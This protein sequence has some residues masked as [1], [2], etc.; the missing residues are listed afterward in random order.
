M[1]NWTTK[2]LLK[3]DYEISNAKITDV[4]LNFENHG[5]LTLDVV[6]EGGGW[7]CCFGGYVLG[8]GHLGSSEFKGSEKGLEAIMRIMDV[9][10]VEA[11]EDMVGKHI[12]VA[13]LGWGHS[14][15]IIGNIINEKWFDY[16]SFFEQ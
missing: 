16:E 13:Q 8:K 2:D 10:G 5:C 9:V 4:S 14:I 15:R 7:S 3:E 6:I 11:L 1:K 12:R